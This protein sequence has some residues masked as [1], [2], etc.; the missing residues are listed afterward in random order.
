MKVPGNTFNTEYLADVSGEQSETLIQRTRTAFEVAKTITGNRE[1]LMLYGGTIRNLLLG[2]ETSEPDYDF[3]GDFDP[4]E[5]QTKYPHLVDSRWDEVSTIRLRIGNCIY[6]FTWAEDIQERLYIGDITLSNL[7][8][9][10]DGCVIDYFGGLASLLNREVKIID[11]DNKFAIDPTRILRVFRFAA[12]LGFRIDETTLSSAIRNAKFIDFSEDIEDELW[13]ILALDP[14]VRSQ[15]L[16]LLRI[17]G[18]DRYFEY[19]D[20]FLDEI[21]AVSLER[22]LSKYTQLDVLA[23]MLAS[24]LYLVG[25]AVRDT[26]WGKRVNDLD[27]KVN[28]PVDDVIAVLEERGF[29]RSPDYRTKEQEY[30]VSQFPGVVGVVIDGMDIHLSSVPTSDIPTLISEGDINFSCCVYDTHAKRILNPEMIREIADKEIHFAN[31]IKALE[32]PVIVINALKQISRTPDIKIPT[33]T[34]DIIK[35]SIPRIVQFIR[36]DPTFRYKIETLC[37]NINSARIYEL[38]E[39]DH[40]DIFNGV[41]MKKRKLE[42]SPSYESLVVDE[43]SEDDRREIIRLLR[44]GYGKHFDESKVFNG[45]VNSV[46]IERRNGRMQA[47]CMVDGERLYA[48]SARDKTDWINIIAEITRNN[49]SVWC[50]VDCNNPK[51]QALCS[52]AGLAI[53]TDPQTIER[54]LKSNTSRYD[55][56]DTYEQDG[57]VVF[58]KRNKPDDYSQVLLRL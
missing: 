4:D 32:D 30:Y 28:M 53:E 1:G 58:K 9:T 16:D 5:I 35:A 26:I 52:V 44:V 41:E 6:D 15:A 18:I 24:D 34:M 49:Y 37:G 2:I 57:F 48:A 10:E 13:K 11:P 42:V 19:P 55:E 3:I 29:T 40:G 14:D 12:E 8:M 27:F 45:R 21:E 36:T 31:P 20:R 33:D 43:L 39:G 25:G 23:E 51:I 46:V 50:T 47:C 17:Y 56:I 7:C 22:A 38:F 54:I